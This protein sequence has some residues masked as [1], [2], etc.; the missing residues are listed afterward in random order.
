MAEAVFHDGVEDDGLPA[1]LDVVDERSVVRRGGLKSLVRD[2]MV[3]NGE[4]LRF[5]RVGLALNFRHS[6]NGRLPVP[7]T[8]HH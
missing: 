1:D 3:P 2:M 5:G 6:G 7:A 4:S 8:L